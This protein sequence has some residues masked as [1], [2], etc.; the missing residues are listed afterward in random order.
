MPI[1]DNNSLKELNQD[2]EA[3]HSLSRL[4]SV[5]RLLGAPGKEAAEALDQAPELLERVRSLTTA[6]DRFNALFRDRGW[7]AYEMLNAETMFAA[8]QLGEAG[9]VDAAEQIL[10][11]YYDPETIQVHLRWMR[12]VQAFRPREELLQLAAVDYAEERYHACVPVVLAQTE[13]LVLDLTR[14]LFFSR[15]PRNQPIEAWDSISAHP[16]GLPSIIP[17]LGEPRNTTDES[18]IDVPYRHGV[19]HGRDL[20]YANKLVAAKAWAALFALQDW[21][22]KLEHGKLEAPPPESPLSWPDLLAKMIANEQQKRAIKDWQPRGTIEDS[23]LVDRHAFPPETPEHAAV[24]FVEAWRVEDF[25]R[26][27][28]VIQRSRV[29]RETL[30][31]EQLRASFGFRKLL[32]FRVVSIQDM[33]PAMTTVRV[34]IN[35]EV[36]GRAVEK[37]MVANVIFEDLGGDPVVRGTRTGVWGVNDISALR[38]EEY[39]GD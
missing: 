3:L 18:S 13:G 16:E 1:Q 23:Y 28:T 30:L 8:I 6:P 32:D 19:L 12:S 27:A 34:W 29:L 9:D 5:L 35:Y 7:V 2:A 26:M 10:A 36:A 15:R 14:E 38:E 22:H 24:E 20:G 25:D 39:R 11:D 4:R 33:A 21:A 31:I 17:L 37:V